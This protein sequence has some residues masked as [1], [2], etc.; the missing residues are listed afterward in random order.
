MAPFATGPA[1][2]AKMVV[3]VVVVGP[4]VVEVEVEVEVEVVVVALGP[5]TVV[6][7]E[8][9]EGADVVVEPMTVVVEAVPVADCPLMPAG[10]SEGAAAKVS[11]AFQYLSSCV[12]E[13]LPRV[14]AYPMLYV[15]GGTVWG[16]SAPNTSNVNALSP[17]SRPPP[18]G[19]SATAVVS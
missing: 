15:P 19:A 11:C 18:P 5:T 1:L 4:V 17:T 8:L 7:V 12:A 14:H 10:T 13:G 9:D 2:A 6:V 16:P 3:V